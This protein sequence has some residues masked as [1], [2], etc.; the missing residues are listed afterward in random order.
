[1]ELWN[2][3][4]EIVNRFSHWPLVTNIAIIALPWGLAFLLGARARWS[5]IANRYRKPEK[6]SFDGKWH[7]PTHL[8]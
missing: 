3:K 1:M 2:L 4:E 5:S 6:L 8:V 7:P